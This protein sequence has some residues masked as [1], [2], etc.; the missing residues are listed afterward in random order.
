MSN[1]FGAPNDPNS[2]PQPGSPEWI[3]WLQSVLGQQPGQPVNPANLPA[4]NAMPIEA[5]APQNLPG[6]NAWPIPPGGRGAY[7]PPPPVR[8]PGLGD[9]GPPGYLRSTSATPPGSPGAPAPG[10]APTDYPLSTTFSSFGPQTGRPAAPAVAGPVDPSII[11]RQKIAAAAPRRQIPNLGYYRPTSGI[12]QGPGTLAQ[13]D[14][15][16]PRR[17]KGPLTMFGA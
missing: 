12:A 8:P 14:P 3:Q 11:A 13:M 7:P 9:Q 10:T 1:Y 15:N 2:V 16:D 5:A 4:A 17:Y 6:S